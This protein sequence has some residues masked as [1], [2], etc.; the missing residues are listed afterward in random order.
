[1]ALR[2]GCYRSPTLFPNGIEDGK[3][4]ESCDGIKIGDC[5]AQRLFFTD[6]PV[7]KPKQCSLLVEGV[8]Q[9]QSEKFEC[10]RC[11]QFRCTSGKS[12]CLWKSKLGFDCE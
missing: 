6:V 3:N 12:V 1:M 8:S 4:S 11:L 5:T 10:G 9:K 7:Q 2:Q